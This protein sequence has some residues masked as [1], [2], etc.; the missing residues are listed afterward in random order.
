MTAITVFRARPVALTIYA[1]LGFGIALQ[2]IATAAYFIWF[3]T[4]EYPFGPVIFALSAFMVA[5]GGWFGI[6]AWRRLRDPEPP[7]V[8]GPAGIH[9]RLLSSRPIPWGA[10]SNLAVRNAGRGGL[11][12]VFDI[13]PDAIA[14][15][16]VNIG[17]R[18]AAV[19]NGLFGYGYRLNHM[20]TDADA[21]KFV[22]AIR[23]YATVSGG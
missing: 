15:S 9:D 14:G 18:M 10:V 8:I 13:A 19:A 22:A 12:V 4:P 16:G 3:D 7:I 2:G 5:F 11:I 23:P 1:L 17:A 6:Q 21:A 20:G